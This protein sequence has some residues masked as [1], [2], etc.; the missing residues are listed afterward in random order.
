MT[1]LVSLLTLPVFASDDDHENYEKDA[2]QSEGLPPMIPHAVKDTADGAYC[3][4][5]HKTGAKHAPVTPHPERLSCTGCHA[6]GE[7]KH[8]KSHKKSGA[9]K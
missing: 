2:E 5:C 1:S 9:K 3:L 4:G 7:I 6:L 8:H